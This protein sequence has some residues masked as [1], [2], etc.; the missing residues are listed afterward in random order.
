MDQ[1]A[2]GEPDRLLFPWHLGVYDAHCHPTDTMPN[3]T[4]IPAMKSRVLTIMATR[5]QDQELV[6]E[7]ANQYCV[8][9]SDTSNLTEGCVVPCFGWHPWFTHQIYNDMEE[10]PSEPDSENFKIQ[11]YI[12]V[13][14]PQ[15]D[16]AID[17]EF[18]CG[19]PQPR[20]LKQFIKQTEAYLKKYPIA[21][22]GEIGLDKS[23]RLPEGQPTKEAKSKDPHMTPGSREGRGLSPFRV[24]IDH[25]KAV[26]MAQL[27]LAGEMNRA[28]S[29][30]GVQVH[31]GLL[32]VLRESWKGYE[33]EVL[34][35][36]ERKK[37]SKAA[38][39][40]QDKK[41]DEA[42][43]NKPNPFPPR[44]CLHSYS[45]PPENLKQYFHQSV[46]ADIFISLSAVINLQKTTDAKATELIVAVPDDRILVE[47]DLHIAGEEM[48]QRL[49][50]M[51]RRICFTK[52]WELENGVKKL[53]QNWHRFVFG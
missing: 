2:E 37:I 40:P 46:P 15:P 44:I 27:K 41:H 5:G 52:K 18:L 47:S 45:G 1:K 33:K 32:E 34:T 24:H 11:H 23:F 53:G 26:L 10:I 38:P 3:V 30:H 29:I 16:Q 51:V 35:K 20:S 42:S 31:G 12:S 8:K 28:V 43:N 39:S 48:D 19:L 36:K 9:S 50:E 25:Q 6:A 13:L 22:V 14:R 4:N 17:L 21:L 7:V 49:E